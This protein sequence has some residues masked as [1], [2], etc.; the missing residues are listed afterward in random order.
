[1]NLIGWMI[2]SLSIASFLGC[3][4]TPKKPSTVS[5]NPALELKMTEAE[6]RLAKMEAT[7][8]HLIAP[9]L[10]SEA[11]YHLGE[12][13]ELSQESA[14]VSEVEGQLKEVNSNLDKVDEIEAQIGNKL[15][16]VFIARKE[17]A[18][19]GAQDQ[20]PFKD[21]D[22]ILTWMGERLEMGF[23]EITP[24]RMKEVVG[25]YSEAEIKE[26]QK[27]ELAQV[28]K[29]FKQIQKLDGDDRFEEIYAAAQED[30]KYA[31]SMIA[32]NK[33]NYAGFK[34]AVDKTQ[35]SSKRLLSL[36]KTAEWVDSSTEEDVA[37]Y[38][39]SKASDLNQAALTNVDY[40]DRPLNDQFVLV[41]AQ[42]E[43]LALDSN[44]L[45]RVQSTNNE[46]NRELTF[47][48]A[49]NTVVK[50]QLAR[51]QRMEQKITEIQKMFSEEEAKVLIENNKIVI[52]MQGIDFPVG[53]SKVPNKSKPLLRKVTKAIESFDNPKVTIEGHTDASGSS[54]VNQKLSMERARSA[55]NMITEMSSFIEKSEVDTVGY[56]FLR[57]LADNKTPSGRAQ[58]RRVDVIISTL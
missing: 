27:R 40:R 5:L 37:L 50:Q 39:E 12:A 42:V 14:E 22:A 49:E 36:S 41:N 26:I 20:Q 46:L 54:L 11:K 32:K 9:G 31:Q 53:Q 57:P 21:A 52:R 1:M 38:L 16:P 35:F 48:T 47:A 6:S 29:R 56:G 15:L 3:E 34:A 58:N 44:R 7:H 4:S 28:E 2:M 8:E 43:S 13:K 18:V 24:E 30:F 25:L 33:D 17:A 23:V 45:N 55:E 19:E 10:F 51:R